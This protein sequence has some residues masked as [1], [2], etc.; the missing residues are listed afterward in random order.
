MGDLQSR[1]VAVSRRFLSSCKGPRWKSPRVATLGKKRVHKE[2][3][4]C[5]DEDTTGGS[6]CEDYGMC[7]ARSSPWGDDI[8]KLV[9]ASV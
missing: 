1:L 4:V 5:T 7:S 6:G 2:D 8:R 3:E 9:R